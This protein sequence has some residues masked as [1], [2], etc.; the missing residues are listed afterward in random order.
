MKLFL[1]SLVI[2]C[3]FFVY[4]ANARIYDLSLVNLEILETEVFQIEEN[5]NYPFDAADIVKIK[6]QVT[7]TEPGLFIASDRMFRLVATASSFLAEPGFDSFRGQSISFKAMYDDNFEVRYQGLESFHY[8]EGC[9]YFHDILLDTETKSYTVCYDVLRRLNIVPVNFEG[10]R[11][12]YLTLMDNTQSNSC[13]NCREL[14]VSSGT[15]ET[16]VPHAK[17]APEQNNQGCRQGLELIFKISDGS[18]GCVKPK[19][20]KK[21]IERGWG[22]KNIPSIPSVASIYEDGSRENSQQTTGQHTRLTLST[23]RSHLY[24]GGDP[25]VFAGTL[26]GSFSGRIPNAE[27][28]IKNDGPC[29]EDHIIAKG[30][31]DQKGKYKI[32]ESAKVWDATDNQIIVHA[33]FAGN[34]KFLPSISKTRNVIVYPSHGEKCEN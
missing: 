16:L 23:P 17:I 14:L 26:W 32:F 1:I 9:E 13:P 10:N 19:T 33:E 7:K 22:S 8:F 6:F 11:H 25:I 4:E 3:S 27:I 12:Y 18:F 34:E 2:F 29:P 30:I 31:T 21:L 5:P 20:A 15:I 24:N 28:I